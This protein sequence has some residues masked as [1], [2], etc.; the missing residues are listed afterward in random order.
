MVPSV[1]RL[2]LAQ[3]GCGWREADVLMVGTELTRGQ[4]NIGR[5]RTTTGVLPSLTQALVG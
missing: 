3:A 4:D 5:P 2:G 1:L